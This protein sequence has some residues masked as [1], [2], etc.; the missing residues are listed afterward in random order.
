MAGETENFLGRGL[1]LEYITLGWNVVGVA[2]VIYAAWKARSVALA[3]FGLDSLIEIGASTVVIWELTDMGKDREKKALRLIGGAFFAL[4][5]YILVQSVRTLYLHI[6]PENSPLGMVWFVLTF[7]A[8]VALAQGKHITG[9]RL[10]NPVLLTEG[11]VTMVDAYLAGSVLVGLVLNT[12]FGW[13]WG[14]STCGSR[15]CLLR[16]QGR[17]SGM[18]GR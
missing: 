17:A 5:A 11:R 4:A 8:M 18:G 1:F 7:A 2:I 15:Y 14:G 3:G 9:T 13:W 16:L 6:R 10:N 12:L